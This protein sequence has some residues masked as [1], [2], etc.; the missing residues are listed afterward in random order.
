MTLYRRASY[1]S[2]GALLLTRMRVPRA[3]FL[4]TYFCGAQLRSTFME[5]NV[6]DSISLLATTK[7]F[8]FNF[9]PASRQRGGLGALARLCD[10]IEGLQWSVKIPKTYLQE[11]V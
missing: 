6:I 7:L 8:Y 2:V 10:G 5:N 1:K 3:R 11:K 9:R 4:R